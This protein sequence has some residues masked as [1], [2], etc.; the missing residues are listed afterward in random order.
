VQQEAEGLNPVEND[1]AGCALSRP[2]F[3]SRRE[4]ASRALMSGRTSIA[5]FMLSA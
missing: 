5:V 1:A 3:G 4:L 2:R